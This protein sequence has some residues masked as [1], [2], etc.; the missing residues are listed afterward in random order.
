[1]EYIYI[2]EGRKQTIYTK[3]WSKSLFTIAKMFKCDMKQTQS[4]WDI[5]KKTN[6]N[7]DL[8][9]LSDKKLLVIQSIREYK[10]S[11]W[12]CVC[13]TL[14][15][16]ALALKANSM[17]SI[18]IILFRGGFDVL[19]L[20]KKTIFA[21]GSVR[22]FVVPR[23]RIHSIGGIIQRSKPEHQNWVIN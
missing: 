1:M 11:P 6:N 9:W 14:V 7:D 13:V 15:T 4:E 5:E 10:S 17:F 2:I 21:L 12:V 18:V 20:N 19:P 3:L 22:A 8:I 16:C 23:S